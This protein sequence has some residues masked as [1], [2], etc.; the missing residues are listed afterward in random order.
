MDNIDDLMR[1]K[2]DSDDPGARFEF[3]EEYW[4]QAQALLE[5]EEARRRKGWLWWILG[6]LLLIS[7]CLLCWR[8]QGAIGGV[9][10]HKEGDANRPLSTLNTE[11]RIEKP[12]NTGGVSAQPKDSTSS[13]HLQT[14]SN[15]KKE[16][17]PEA[18]EGVN[19]GSVRTIRN[20]PDA[21][22][23]PGS[24]RRDAAKTTQQ[25][26]ESK[27]KQL[28][29]EAPFSKTSEAGSTVPVR[30]NPGAEAKQEKA[31]GAEKSKV[32]N[33]D[34][35]VE[36]PVS[37]LQYPMSILP[38][39]LRALLIPKQLPELKPVPTAKSEPIAKLPDPTKDSRFSVG[40][41]LAGAAYPASD[42]LG[43]WAGWTMGAFGGYKWK[44]DWSLR[45]GAQV[46]FMP[47]YQAVADS[48]HPVLVE[49][50]RYSFGYSKEVYTRQTQGLYSLEM[51]LAVQW[52]KAA[53]GLEA[54][55]TAGMLFWVQ[56]R[57]SLT[58]ESSLDPTHTVVKK[59]VRG[60][61]SPYNKVYGS[62][63]VGAEYRFAKRFAMMARAQYRLTPVFK[64]TQEVASNHGLGNVECGIRVRLF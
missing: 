27:P 45:L 18:S 47:G 28:R 35:Q 21:Q 38:T 4:E 63:F 36:T 46:R 31:D 5:Q 44:P 12:E 34:V 55:A 23:A 54:G 29:K 7:L 14:A 17:M 41:Q 15:K 10:T 58:K 50:L 52:N 6:A 60:D 42:T 16:E 1:Q 40:L 2:F 64:N 48:T 57:T 37:R 8:G 39:P 62:A 24:N 32:Q 33:T 9:Q 51:P 11:T 30:E 25:D 43:R 26:S 49:Q 3:R 13:G 19:R 20:H 56:D 59:F 61:A 22:N 53:W